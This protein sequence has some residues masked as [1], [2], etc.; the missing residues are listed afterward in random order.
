MIQKYAKKSKIVY[1]ANGFFDPELLIYAAEICDKNGKLITTQHGGSFGS[2]LFN[3]QEIVQ[4]EISD[5]FLS[6]GWDDK[7]YQNVIAM[8]TAT[9]FN[10]VKDIRCH[11]NYGKLLLI[12]TSALRCTCGAGAL[13]SFSFPNYIENQFIFYECLSNDAKKL[14]NIRLF[15]EDYWDFRMQWA[16]KYPDA[17]TDSKGK[18]FYELLK[19]SV[20]IYRINR[21]IR[22]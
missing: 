7:S 1:A 13:S 20:E 10:Y 19:S 4:K 2:A 3:L 21:L 15:P 22:G 18:T 17:D 5:T 6:W 9:K 8:S 14:L 12:E 16:D 11:N